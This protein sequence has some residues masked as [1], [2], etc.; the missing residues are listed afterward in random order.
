MHT[1]SI[2]PTLVGAK[3]VPG[4]KATIEFSFCETSDLVATAG[5]V[6]LSQLPSSIVARLQ[7]DASTRL[8][9]GRL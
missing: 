6:I 3:P 8:L 2:N 9:E 7:A 5:F 4:P 1:L